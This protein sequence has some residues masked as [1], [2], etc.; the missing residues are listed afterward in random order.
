MHLAGALA[1]PIMRIPADGAACNPG[2]AIA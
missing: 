1:G 2:T